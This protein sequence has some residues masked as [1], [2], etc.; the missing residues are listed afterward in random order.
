[1]RRQFIASSVAL[2]CSAA[3]ARTVSAQGAGPV[4]GKHY[5]SIKPPVPTSDSKKIEVI[6][7]FWYGCPH[8]FALEPLMAEWAKTLGSDVAFRKEHIG[9]PNA[10]KHQQL[11]VAL[12]AMG[13]ESSMT[14]KIF[15]AIHKERQG[16]TS[17][18]SIADFVEKQGVDRKKF[19]DV[20]ES[21]SV[22]TKMR[23]TTALSDSYGLDAVPAFTVNGRYFTAPGM[24]GGGTQVL[25]LVD[26]L[27][28]QERARVK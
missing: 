8:C 7:F 16:L 13:L 28:K 5:R 19:T 22:K 4:D 18:S 9:F 23:N 10:A 26:L 25:A 3:L 15:N 11:F 20:Y 17:T 27:I 14:P 12:G 1:M 2:A 6:E 21:F 24:A